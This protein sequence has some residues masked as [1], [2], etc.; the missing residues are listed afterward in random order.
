MTSRARKPAA[1]AGLFG[2]TDSTIAPSVLGSFIV[3]ASSAVTSANRTPIML[4]APGRGIST[5]VCA[6]AGTAAIVSIT[7]NAC[8]ARMGNL[9]KNRTLYFRR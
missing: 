5:R 1:L 3:F 2:F 6:N 9:L 7:T 4:A 8:I